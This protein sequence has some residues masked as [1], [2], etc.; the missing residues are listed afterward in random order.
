MTRDDIFTPILAI[1][2]NL[3]YNTAMVYVF[4]LNNTL[5]VC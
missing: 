1:S 2:T 5:Y 3:S 4:V